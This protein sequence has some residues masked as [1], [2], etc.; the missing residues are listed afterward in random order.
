MS[1]C[2]QELFRTGSNLR[3][4]YIYADAL[5]NAEVRAESALANHPLESP[6][7]LQTRAILP[8]CFWPLSRGGQ[9]SARMVRPVGAGEDCLHR[10]RWFEAD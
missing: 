4:R 9:D 6:V 5:K 10:D 1:N 8:A 2:V 3:P 7:R